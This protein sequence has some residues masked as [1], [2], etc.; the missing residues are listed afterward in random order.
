MKT[1]RCCPSRIPWESSSPNS[2]GGAIF[3]RCQMASLLRCGVPQRDQQRLGGLGE[4]AV[5]R[6]RRRSGRARVGEAGLQY[7]RTARRSRRGRAR[8]GSSRRRP[9]ADEL[10]GAREPGGGRQLGVDLPA[11]AEPAEQLVRAR[12]RRRRG[13]DPSTPAAARSSVSGPAAGGPRASSQPCTSSCPAPRRPGG[14][15]AARKCPPTSRPTRPP[16]SR[17]AGSGRSQSL[18]ESTSKYSPR[19]RRT[20]RRTGR[21]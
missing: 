10:R 20:R 21:G 11:A 14:R 19:S 13:R 15:R 6:P 3:V 16:R 9:R 18:A 2:L 12:S 1:G 17:S 4:E 5:L 7:S 8:K